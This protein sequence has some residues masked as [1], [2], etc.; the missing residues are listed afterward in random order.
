MDGTIPEATFVSR[1]TEKKGLLTGHLTLNSYCLARVAVEKVEH[2]LE[3]A[4]DAAVR[5]DDGLFAQD[6]PP[7]QRPE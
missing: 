4:A 3:P 7:L 6:V 2:A 1:D 5:S